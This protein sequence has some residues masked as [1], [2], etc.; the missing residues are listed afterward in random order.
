MITVTVRF[1][2]NERKR[3]IRVFGLRSG[4]VRRP[5]YTIYAV[6][7]YHRTAVDISSRILRRRQNS[8]FFFFTA[9]SLVVAECFSATSELLHNYSVGY[10]VFFF[11]DK[12]QK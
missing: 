1:G 9:Y 4:S 2:F 12:L 8:F 3:L 11:P 10:S 5:A 6:P 7:V